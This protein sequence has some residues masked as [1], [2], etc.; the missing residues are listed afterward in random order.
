M[1]K[2]I[3]LLN[4]NE[5][6]D[7]FI[8]ESEGLKGVIYKTIKF[9]KN[10]TDFYNL[11]FGDRSETNKKIDDKARSNNGDRDKV[12]ATVAHAVMNFVL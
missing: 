6:N 12:L 5:N 2:E 11:A 8:F 4:P 10:R 1:N 7:E 9:E 3:Y